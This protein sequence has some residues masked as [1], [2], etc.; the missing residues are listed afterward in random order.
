MGTEVNK[1]NIIT[2]F[3]TIKPSKT[4]DDINDRC[5]LTCDHFYVVLRP[6]VRLQKLC[7]QVIYFK[8]HIWS[9]LFRVFGIFA[10]TY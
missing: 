6:P 5:I 9:V 8:D 10:D 3:H 2:I 1:G 7:M 4:R